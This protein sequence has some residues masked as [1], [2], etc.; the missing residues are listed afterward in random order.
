MYVS[1]SR[2]IGAGAVDGVRGYPVGGE[3]LR[4]GDSFFEFVLRAVRVSSGERW[5]PFRRKPDW[6]GCVGFPIFIF[7]DG[8]RSFFSDRFSENILIQFF[9]G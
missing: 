8:E 9:E 3:V 4:R 7:N 6:V 1:Y 2:F 5:D